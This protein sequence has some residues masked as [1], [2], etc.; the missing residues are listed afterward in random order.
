MCQ[1][2]ATR[3]F[4]SALRSHEHGLDRRVGRLV[5]DARLLAHDKAEAVPRRPERA[6]EA[7]AAGRR[8]VGA[9]A[10]DADD[11]PARADTDLEL[12]QTARGVRAR[13]A[14]E[15]PQ[16]LAVAEPC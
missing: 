3:A 16:G 7:V 15:K 8:P 4:E 10:H 9:R 12:R 2:T 13:D 11:D 5:G 6:A 14:A 1:S